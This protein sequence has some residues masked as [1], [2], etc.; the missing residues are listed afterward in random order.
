M[1]IGGDYCGIRGVYWGGGMFLGRF[2][3][4][5]IDLRETRYIGEL[6]ALFKNQTPV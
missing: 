5:C 6:R 3:G 2:E 1:G 4:G